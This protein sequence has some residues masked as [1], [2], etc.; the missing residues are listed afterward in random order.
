MPRALII[1]T[2]GINCDRELGRAFELA[3]A[4]PEFVHLNRL[5]AQPRLIDQFDLI[6]LPG[7]FSYGDAIAAG[8]IAAQLMRRTLYASFVRAIERGVP[9][10]AP[11]NGFQMAVQLGLLP[12]PELGQPW[13]AEPPRPSAAL[14]QNASG[15]F[16]DRW[17]AI[18]FPANTRCIWTQSVQLEPSTALLPIAHGE[19]RFVPESDDLVLRLAENGQIAVRFSESDNP[20]GSAANIAGICDASG[21]VLGLMPHPERY[22]SWNQH[23]FWTRLSPAEMSDEPPG[24]RMFR[25]AVAYVS[26]KRQPLHAA[27]KK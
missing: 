13:P 10:I 7:G 8:R 4:H 12:G 15:R 27:R 11:C 5:M 26:E 23:P 18:E 9:I 14:A 22:T 17:C 21:L 3:G 20:N 6:G 16:I 25:N 1:T 19:G 2:A 24:L